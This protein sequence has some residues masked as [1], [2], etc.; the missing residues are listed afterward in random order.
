MLPC[1]FRE[2]PMSDMQLAVGIVEAGKM[3]SLSRSSVYNLISA[4]KLRTIRIGSRRLIP[5]SSIRALIGE[6]AA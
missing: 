6:E 1:V 2:L 3:L 5:M 4:N